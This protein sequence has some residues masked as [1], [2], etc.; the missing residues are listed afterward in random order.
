MNKM[1]VI[2]ETTERLLVQV[3]KKKDV[4]DW[5]RRRVQDLVVHGTGRERYRR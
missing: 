3:T 4:G 5:V 2:V 1:K